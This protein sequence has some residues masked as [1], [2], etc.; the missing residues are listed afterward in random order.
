[1]SVGLPVISSN[2]MSGPL[3]LLNENELVSIE[4]GGFFEA[5]YG[6]LVNVNDIKGLSKAIQ[7]LESNKSVRQDYSKDS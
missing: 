1:M 5:K 7:F 2:C 6:I 3:E 4:S